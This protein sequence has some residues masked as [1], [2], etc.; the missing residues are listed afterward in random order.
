MLNLPV[1]SERRGLDDKRPA[2]SQRCSIIA[3]R[4]KPRDRIKSSRH[5]RALG[6]NFFHLFLRLLAL[7]RLVIGTKGYRRG[8]HDPL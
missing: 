1:A 5:A 8:G 6:V 2:D 7:C 3:T 4:R